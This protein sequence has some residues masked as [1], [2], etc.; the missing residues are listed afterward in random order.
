MREEKIK[1][2]NAMCGNTNPLGASWPFLP[3][4][5]PTNERTN[6]QTNERTNERTNTGPGGRVN[7]LHFGDVVLQV[8]GRCW[9][10]RGPPG[11]SSSV[12]D[13]RCRSSVRR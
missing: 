1:R 9:I 7:F 4:I 10:P 11:G 2:V 3:P 6:E 12:S 8:N 13:E 5:A